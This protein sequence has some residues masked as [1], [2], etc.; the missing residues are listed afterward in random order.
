MLCGVVGDQRVDSAVDIPTP[1]IFVGT[2]TDMH[3][4]TFDYGSCK[5]ALDVDGTRVL[6]PHSGDGNGVHILEHISG[7][8]VFGKVIEILVPGCNI[9]ITVDDGASGTVYLWGVG[10]FPIVMEEDPYM[11][12]GRDTPLSSIVVSV[13]S[14][15]DERY[16]HCAVDAL[17]GTISEVQYPTWLFS[18]DGSSSARVGFDREGAT[19]DEVTVRPDSGAMSVDVLF[20]CANAVVAVDGISVYDPLTISLPM[21]ATT[22][23]IPWS[24]AAANPF[25]GLVLGDNSYGLFPGLYR[26][27]LVG[28]FAYR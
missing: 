15:G 21:M 12:S 23:T 26:D 2:G 3:D 25:V 9:S 4:V 17:H 27:A 1:I 20:T 5:L 6:M 7:A 13:A 24:D 19:L 16:V 14:L 22:L 18:L 11:L 8:T 10:G 28:F